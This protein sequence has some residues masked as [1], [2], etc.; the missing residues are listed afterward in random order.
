M[1]KVPKI[2]KAPGKIPPK[3]PEVRRI[4]D[5]RPNSAGFDQFC[6][7]VLCGFVIGVL[8]TWAIFMT[9]YYG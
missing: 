6:A 2:P 7:G 9:V 8:F 5:E 1:L 4:K 3:P